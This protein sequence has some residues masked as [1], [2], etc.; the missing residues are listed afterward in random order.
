MDSQSHRLETRIREM[1][2]GLREGSPQMADLRES[3]IAELTAIRP[4]VPRDESLRL[5]VLIERLTGVRK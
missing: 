1:T 5:E 4:F 2:L 3:L